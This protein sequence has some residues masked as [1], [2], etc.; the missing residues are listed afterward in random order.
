MEKVAV[1][2][3]IVKTYFIAYLTFSHVYI[4]MCAHKLMFFKSIIEYV[5]VHS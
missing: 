2:K 1:S 5:C 4:A 3:R